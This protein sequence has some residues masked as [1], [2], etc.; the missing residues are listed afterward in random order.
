MLGV[1][2]LGALQ[3]IL[4]AVGLSMLVL[5]VRSSRPTDMV[6]GRVEGVAGFH[7][8]ALHEGA[9]RIPGIV[10]YRFNAPLIFFNAA[11]FKR[12]VLEFVAATP[13]ATWL[14]VDGA[15]IV[16]LDSTGADTLAALA[17]ELSAEGKRLVIAGA[18]A[19]VQGMLERSGALEHIGAALVFPTLRSA[20]DAYPANER[21][22][23]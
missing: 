20:V 5:L 1:V 19:R 13:D 17:D 18:H 7:N 2:T 9:T 10:L 16:N 15:P 12:R 22:S 3:G 14:V 23:K 6:L 21:V 4:L 11:Y 8:V